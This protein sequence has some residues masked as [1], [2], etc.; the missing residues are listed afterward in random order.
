M[1]AV[2]LT[3]DNILS[4]NN[5]IKGYTE[6][7]VAD[8]EIKYS[9]T[10]NDLDIV[11]LLDRT[12]CVAVQSKYDRQSNMPKSTLGGQTVRVTALATSDYIKP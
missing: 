1:K 9:E 6:G 7:R 3:S 2:E 8:M 10:I 4:V 5:K 12:V 11:I